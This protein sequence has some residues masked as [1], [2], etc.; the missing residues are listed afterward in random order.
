MQPR[1]DA[2]LLAFSGTT[3]AAD[4]PFQC[5]IFEYSTNFGA[6]HPP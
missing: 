4:D 1:E 3:P 5:H 2:E 6:N